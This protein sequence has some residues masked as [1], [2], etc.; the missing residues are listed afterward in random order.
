MRQSNRSD[1]GSIVSHPPPTSRIQD[2]TYGGSGRAATA[3]TIC[4]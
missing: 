2:V 4:L 1:L 3:R